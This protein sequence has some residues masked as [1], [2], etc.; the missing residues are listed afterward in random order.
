MHSVFQWYT[1]APRFYLAVEL[2][3]VFSALAHSLTFSQR[4][5]NNT[6]QSL[7]RAH[8]SLLMST[9][10]QTSAVHNKAHYV[11]LIPQT[12]LIHFRLVCQFF[13]FSSRDC[14][15]TGLLHSFSIDWYCY[16]FQFPGAWSFSAP[17]SIVGCRSTTLLVWKSVREKGQYG[18]ALG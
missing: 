17:P 16:N 3:L 4:C 12:A 18:A 11:C 8:A 13:A 5:V 6:L 9:A 7:T 15:I 1:N 10:F 2:S 14:Y